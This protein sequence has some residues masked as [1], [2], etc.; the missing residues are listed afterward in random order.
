MR[1]RE[2]STL[3]AND[4][5]GLIAPTV[6][7]RIAT[8]DA[9]TVDLARSSPEIRVQTDTGRITMPATGTGIIALGD[10]LNIPS[11]FLG[12]I[13]P[14]VQHSLLNALLSRNDK[15]V[16][17]QY[18]DA[19]LYDVVPD[20]ARQI[21][22]ARVVD[23]ACRVAG[24]DS[25]VIDWRRDNTGYNFDIVTTNELQWGGDPQVGDIT[26]GG[27]RFGQDIKHNLAPWV[28]RYLYRLICTN[29]METPSVARIIAK[30]ADT[31]QIV[32]ALEE[33]AFAAFAKLDQDIAAFYDLR[34]QEVDNPERTLVRIATEHGLSDTTLADLI[35]DLPEYVHENGHATMFD[36][37]NLVTNYANDDRFV[38]RWTAR[39]SLE[40]AGGRIANDHASRCP[41]C[42]S[43][44]SR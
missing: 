17:V 3:T 26:R 25:A 5:F 11:K 43:K 19:G 12:R 20:N 13:D 4:L 22:P 15:A 38:N 9:I 2:E 37:V 34:T 24:P 1:L 32:E 23:I 40:L 39:R 16:I 30:G 6:N 31:D 35:V 27:L 29:G 8:T 36:L 21:D 28:S 14:E 44:L 41:Q 18:T 7:E 33:Q 42:R 10:W